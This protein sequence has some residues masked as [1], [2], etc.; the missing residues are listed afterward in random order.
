MKPSFPCVQP[1]AFSSQSQL[2]FLCRHT[3]T[4][5]HTHFPHFHF[6]HHTN[7]SIYYTFY[8]SLFVHFIVYL[9]I[10]VLVVHYKSILVPFYNC[11]VFHLVGGPVFI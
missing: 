9:A 11:I 6:S 7:R 8:P 5:T 2:L 4:H 10:P 1:P 3:H